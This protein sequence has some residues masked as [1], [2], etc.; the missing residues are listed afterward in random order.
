[1]T[2]T[3]LL[4]FHSKILYHKLFQDVDISGASVAA[5]PLHHVVITDCRELKTLALSILW[6]HN[7]VKLHE[8]W[9]GSLQDEMG[10]S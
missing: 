2:A 3:I 8:I 7:P 9:S 6:W 5:I 10:Y 1:M 4:F